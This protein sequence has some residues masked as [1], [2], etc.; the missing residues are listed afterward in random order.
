MKRFALAIAPLAI[1]LSAAP[2]AAGELW[3][4]FDED[5][6]DICPDEGEFPA[7]K[8]SEYVAYNVYELAKSVDFHFEDTDAVAASSKAYEETAYD[9]SADDQTSLRSMIDSAMFFSRNILA[10]VRRVVTVDGNMRDRGAVAIAPPTGKGT[11]ERLKIGFVSYLSSVQE[12]NAAIV[13]DYLDALRTL[14]EWVPVDELIDEKPLRSQRLRFELDEFRA[15]YGAL[16]PVLIE[17]I[18]AP[19]YTAML[20]RQVRTACFAELGQ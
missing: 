17:A 9:F 14:N 19:G 11:K 16:R 5:R 8:I 18:E 6:V 3:S 4:D 7:D 13:Y 2:I 1:L 10:P 12:D 15:A 20:E